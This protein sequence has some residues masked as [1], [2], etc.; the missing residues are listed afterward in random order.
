MDSLSIK[1]GKVSQFSVDRILTKCQIF[2]KYFVRLT[3]GPAEVVVEFGCFLNYKSSSE[4]KAIKQDTSTSGE[5]NVTVVRCGQSLQQIIYHRV[6]LP[7][8]IRENIRIKVAKV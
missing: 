5:Q 8:R 2:N 3:I 7:K 4:A 1:H 6:M